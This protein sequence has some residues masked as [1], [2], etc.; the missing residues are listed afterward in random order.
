MPAS[1]VKLKPIPVELDKKRNL[2]FD[3]NAYAELEEKFGT[4]QAALDLLNKQQF[5][6]TRFLLWAGLQH[7]DE[8]LTEHQV[9]AM[10]SPA[11]LAHISEPLMQAIMDSLPKEDDSKNK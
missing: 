4:V 3:M 10:V 11:D 8:N 7:E 9:G 6:A 5:K 2:K 1:D